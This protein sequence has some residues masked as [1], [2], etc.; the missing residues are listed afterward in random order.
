MKTDWKMELE[1]K[2][3]YQTIMI[4]DKIALGVYFLWPVTIYT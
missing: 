3:M 4:S 2:R 1:Q